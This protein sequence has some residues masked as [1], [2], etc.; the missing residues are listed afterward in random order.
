MLPYLLAVAGGYL[1]GNSMEEKFAAGGMTRAAGQISEMDFDDI[2]YNITE[3]LKANTYNDENKTFWFE[4]DTPSAATISWRDLGETKRWSIH[5]DTRYPDYVYLFTRSGDFKFSNINDVNSF[6]N[7]STLIYPKSYSKGLTAL[8]IR[9]A[10]AF[11]YQDQNRKWNK[12]LD[13]MAGGGGITDSKISELHKKIRNQTKSSDVLYLSRDKKINI[14]D[15]SNLTPYAAQAG[16]EL[17]VSFNAPNSTMLIFSNKV[18]DRFEDRKSFEKY[19]GLIYIF[20]PLTEEVA[21]EI[22]SVVII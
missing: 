8:N 14:G 5:Y 18:Q 13:V 15:Y 6:I 9:N 10:L 22:L 17:K 1:I 12:N 3:E 16:D 4:I 19:K 2:I 21:S 7:T 20:E 11:A